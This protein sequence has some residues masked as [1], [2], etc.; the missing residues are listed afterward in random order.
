MGG[1]MVSGKYPTHPSFRLEVKVKVGVRFIFRFVGGVGGWVDGF[2]EMPT[3][4]SHR[5]ESRAGLGL[6]LGL[7]EGWVVSQKPGL[8]QVGLSLGQ[9]WNI[10]KPGIPC[11]LLWSKEN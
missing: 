2:W 5:L 9:L 6:S 4:L 8:I 7:W 10:T 11:Q 3:H 1:W